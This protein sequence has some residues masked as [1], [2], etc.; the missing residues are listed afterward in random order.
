M[1]A[2]FPALFPGA[3]PTHVIRRGVLTCSRGASDCTFVLT[4]PQDVRSVE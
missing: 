2:Q 3:T 1:T 4:L